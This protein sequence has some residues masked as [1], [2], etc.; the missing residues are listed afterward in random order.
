MFI[1]VPRVKGLALTYCSKAAIELLPMRIAL[2][3]G[4]SINSIKH[5]EN[6]LDLSFFTLR[7]QSQGLA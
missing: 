4:L 7:D 6:K 5:K 1:W 2:A 3:S